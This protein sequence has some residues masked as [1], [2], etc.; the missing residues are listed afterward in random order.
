M[1]NLRILLL[2][3]VVVVVV[4]VGSVESRAGPISP[5]LGFP[6]I[7]GLLER[8]GEAPRRFDHYH[9]A[10]GPLLERVESLRSLEMAGLP[11][12]SLFPNNQ[13]FQALHARRELHPSRFD[14]YHPLLGPLL[15]EDRRLQ[16]WTLVVESVTF[17][18]SPL[19]PL[20]SPLPPLESP[21]P[22]LESP[23]P[24]LESLV[25]PFSTGDV[26]MPP[27]AVLPPI[28]VTGDG[29][30]SGMRPALPGGGGV[31]ETPDSSLPLT[32]VPVPEP[33]GLVLTLIG[34]VLVLVTAGRRAVRMA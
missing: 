30:F 26:T 4:V 14:H 27:V 31:W 9:P 28:G 33:G 25:P 2:A 13:K 7:D 17:P 15:A 1:K 11:S 8:R 16:D 24:P 12:G 10:L 20:E 5:S 3:V 23:L 29:D 19:P 18:E 32:T 6:T 34:L 22:P 21:L